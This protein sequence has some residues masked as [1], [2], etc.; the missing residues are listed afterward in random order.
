[1]LWQ[2]DIGDLMTLLSDVSPISKYGAWG[3]QEY[4]GQPLRDAP[5]AKAVSLFLAS[6]G[7]N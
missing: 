5:K 2:R 4:V 6:Q 7:S 3:L 1:M